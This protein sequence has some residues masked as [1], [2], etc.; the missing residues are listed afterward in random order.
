MS[1]SDSKNIK[2]IRSSISFLFSLVSFFIVF[3]KEKSSDTKPEIIFFSLQYNL[4]LFFVSLLDIRF[5]IFLNNVI[6]D[7]VFVPE[8][9]PLTTFK[10]KICLRFSLS[11]FL[12][13]NSII[14]SILLFITFFFKSSLTCNSFILSFVIKKLTNNSKQKNLS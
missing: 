12:F 4:I 5:I 6:L 14:P 8:T 7:I 1:F 2:F 11:L 10:N 13:I 3:M 9:I